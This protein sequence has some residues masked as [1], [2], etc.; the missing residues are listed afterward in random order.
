MCKRKFLLLLLAGLALSVAATAAEIRGTVVG[1]GQNPIEGAVVLHRSSGAKTE[2]DA[3]GRFALAVPDSDR[4]RIEVIHPDHY[5]SEYLL[6][7]KDLDRRVILGLVPLIQKREE[8]LVT[9]LRY[10]ESSLKVPAAAS[11]IE[12]GALSETRA[13]NITEGL[14]NVPG[15]DAIGSGGFSLVPTV[16][17]LARRRVLYLVDGA[18][19]ESD[20]RTGPNASFVHPETIGRIEV[21]RSASSV[22]YGSDAIGGVIHLMTRSPSF[23]EGLHGRLRTA[24]GT[25]NQEKG[26]GL[27]FE[28]AKGA[29]GFLFSFQ[30]VDAEDYYSPLGRALQSYFT[31]GNLLAKVVHKTDRREIEAGFLGARGKDIGKP[32]RTSDVNPTWYPRENQN[33]FQLGWKEKGLGNGGELHF[34]AFANPNFLE[35][36]RETIA[37]YRTTEEYA[38]TESTEYGAQVSYAKTWE[39]VIRLESGV[40]FFG[41]GGAGAFNRYTSFDETGAVTGT[42]EEY[43]FTG[44]KRTDLGAF[45]SADFFKVR[46]LDL[47]GGLRWDVIRQQALPLGAEAVEQSDKT[48]TTGFFALSYELSPGLTAFANVSKAYRVPSLNELFYTGISGRGY[49]VGNPGLVPETSFN[50]DGGLKLMGRRFFAGLYGFRYEIK[51]MI[52]RYRIDATTRTYGN[53]EKGRIQGLEF[54]LDY[55]VAPGWKIFGN[56]AALRGRSVL[57]GDPLNDIPPLSLHVGTKVWVR[58]LSAELSGTFRLRKG[59]PGPDEVEIAGS[60]ILNLRAGYRWSSLEIFMTLANIFDATY[61]ARPDPDAVEEPGRNLKVGFVYSF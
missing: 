56:V 4:F 1:T 38:L 51:D 6:T 53:I 16:R 45:L 13:P 21:L 61:L 43:P 14:Q 35:T 22:F 30:A 18:R 29:T 24:Y 17:G 2:T 15:V 23:R 26:A 3:E 10:P 60:E 39:D 31:Q 7:R 27:E 48:Q 47:L 42:V 52:E 40:D 54:E 32:L 34:K 19:V 46:G 55:F 50:L 20:R 8:I 5:E 58:H 49:I 44:G 28:G 59:S 33:L 12:S 9:A 11:V 36:D 25:V 41:R 57:S 37:D